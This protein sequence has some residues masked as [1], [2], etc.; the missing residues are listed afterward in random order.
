MHGGAKGAQAKGEWARA[1]EVADKILAR[2]PTSVAA[3][4][5]RGTCAYELGDLVAARKDLADAQSLDFDP[6]IEA[7]L[8]ACISSLKGR[9]AKTR[10]EPPPAGA[11]SAPAADAGLPDLLGALR[12]PDVMKGVSD[13]LRDPAAL[14]ALQ[15]SDLFKQMQSMMPPP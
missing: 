5:V 1:R 4:R 15:N 14:S 13:V 3:L 6:D 12:N 11:T 9:S 7:T 2:R 10:E 8:K